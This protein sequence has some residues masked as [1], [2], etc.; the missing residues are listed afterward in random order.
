MEIKVQCDCGQKF[1]FDVEPVNGQV[2]FAVK[3]PV[4][5]MDGTPRANVILQQA[6]ASMP[7]PP[8]PPPRPIGLSISSAPQPVASESAPPPPPAPMRPA[9]LSIN[10]PQSAQHAPPPAPMSA[11]K[12]KNNENEE[13]DED[14]E[15]GSYGVKVTNLGWKGYALI[16]FFILIAIGGSWLKSAERNLV[17]NTLDWIWE[18]ATGST[19]KK[20]KVIAVPVETSNQ[21][22]TVKWEVLPADSAT[23]IFV[24]TEDQ[25]AVIA[26]CTEFYLKTFKQKL[27]TG[28]TTNV[29]NVPD[30]ALYIV[31]PAKLGT[32][33]INGP[34][35]FNDQIN[36]NLHSMSEFIS[37]KLSAATVCALIGDDAETGIVTIYE[38][39]ERKFHSEHS[40]TIAAGDIKDVTKVTGEEWA[41]GLG[42][43]TGVDGYKKFSM[44]DAERLVQL[45]GFKSDD[46][47]PEKC[48]VLSKTIVKN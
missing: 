4:C 44:D 32:V 25:P 47:M 22:S 48:T 8:P 16:A 19:S 21:G 41:T 14:G 37:R 2:P 13:E 27:F 45:L 7:A 40:I 36:T 15:E 20:D 6:L 34:S 46:E 12:K 35:F 3:C 23:A 28:T 39:G 42:F 1:K 10:R 5:G 26:A 38:N 30:S 29:H 24:K 9:G 11:T 33:E 18:K 43:K 17:R 31:L